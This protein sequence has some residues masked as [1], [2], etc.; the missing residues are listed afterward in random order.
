ML[1]H[2]NQ[3]YTGGAIET[4]SAS[5]AFLDRLFDEVAPVPGSNAAVQCGVFPDCTA[6]VV[7]LDDLESAYAPEGIEC[8]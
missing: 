6:K 7:E 8:V 3:L 2:F 4:D 5:D 1:D